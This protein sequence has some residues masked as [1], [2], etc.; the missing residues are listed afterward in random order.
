VSARTWLPEPGGRQWP[1]AAK[2]SGGK[3]VIHTTLLLV[4]LL[5]SGCHKPAAGPDFSTDEKLGY[6][7][8]AGELSKVMLTTVNGGAGDSY[9]EW[10]GYGERFSFSNDGRYFTM[11][12]WRQSSSQERG[13]AHS[14]IVTTDGSASW[15]I[16]GE[17]SRPW[18]S[19]IR[20][21]VYFFNIG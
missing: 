7:V 1:A 8:K 10:P 14:I 13:H 21:K 18:F 2:V 11:V 4:L 6:I 3:V 12:L 5:F 9:L 15:N 17:A 19:Q 16:P 20:A